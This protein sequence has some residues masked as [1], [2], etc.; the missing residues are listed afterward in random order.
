MKFNLRTTYVVLTVFLF[1]FLLKAQDFQVKGKVIDAEKAPLESAT[2][3][4]EKA[5]DST[6][7]DYTIS[8][9]DGKFSVEGSTDANFINIFISFTGFN[10][11]EKQFSLEE[12]SNIDL[13]EVT[14]KFSTNSLDEVLV[15]GDRAP[16]TIKKD[17]L[18]FN[19]ASFKTQPDA[20]V[21]EVLKQLPGVNVDNDGTITVNGKE[22]SRILVN[23]KEFFGDDPKIAT[24][25]LPKEIIDKIQVVDTK[26]K[27]EEFT[28]EEGDSENK[29]INLTVKEDKNKGY[30]SRLTAGGGTDERYELSGIANYFKDELRLSVLGSSNNINSSGFTFDEVFDAMGRSAYSINGSGG[31]GGI[32]KSDNAGF[33]FA[34]EWNEKADLNSN[35]FFNR[36]DN[37]TATTTT[38]ENILPD[39]TYF[40]NS[41]STS[42]RQNDNHRARV[43][44]EFKPDTLTR[45]SFR[46]NINV[47]KGFSTNNS[48]TESFE[49]DGT[50]I[51]NVITEQNG[52]VFSTNYSNR[53]DVTRKFGSKGAF[54]RLGFNN[55]NNTS[56]DDQVYYSSREIYDEAGNLENTEIQD[57]YIDEDSQEDEYEIEI[58]SRLPLTEKLS[59]DIEYSYRKNNR[60]NTRLVYDREEGEEDYNSLN[61]NLSNDFESET[62]D[63]QPELGLVYNSDK[64]RASFSGG[65]QNIRL[66]NVDL[67]TNN[68]FDNTY[69][70]LFVNSYLRYELT[71]TKSIYFNYRSSRNTPSLNQLQPVTNTTNPLNIVTGNPNLDPTLEHSFYANFNNYDFKSRSGFYAYLGGSL[72]NDR[73]VSFTTTDE[74]LVRTT[75]YT[76]VDGAYS[77]FAGFS[78]NKKIE[79]ENGNALNP[80]VGFRANFN[81]N[82]GFSNTQKYNSETLSLSPQLALRYEIEELL[83]VDPRY[84]LTY[85]NASYSLDSSR[86]QNYINHNLG[87]EVTSYWPKNFIFGNDISYQHVGNMSPG[88]KNDFVL[89]NM[90]LGY[91]LL[92]DDGIFK[93]KIFDVLDENI[94]TSR[95]T[96]EDFIQDTQQL[97]LEQYVMFS[98]TYKFS[99][100]GGKDPNDRRRGRF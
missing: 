41:E 58:D 31:G 12:N 62:F 29:T 76:N 37:R 44:F 73:V 92:G 24:K 15:K 39:R 67:F 81:R 85:N 34:N 17:T 82:V 20:N 14:M 68:S 59:L 78:L 87:M 91:K 8:D 35:Y 22:V 25:N 65:I 40:N 43:N 28:G 21:E 6:L 3:Y 74:D 75:T 88:F 48:F 71:K 61:D 97:V 23:G 56:E 79:L 4:I 80:R 26:T 69:N 52:E 9:V 95:Y 98:F 86:D 5:Q 96:G 18:E 77:A 7:V 53:F 47:N 51:N 36:A 83:T 60:T 55:T 10:T 100:F 57:Q 32:T 2:I 13:G 93:V 16:V 70:N 94:S 42:E 50:P 66:K 99:K 1:S 54:I 72:Y 63:H 19:A 89:W 30:F 84:Q 49:E 27:S 90:S 64:L 38:R 45:I 46:P 11:Y 33:N